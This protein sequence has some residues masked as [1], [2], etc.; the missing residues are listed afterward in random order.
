MI[1]DKVKFH[2]TR[3]DVI[4]TGRAKV[5]LNIVKKCSS[6][7]RLKT[8]PLYPQLKAPLPAPQTTPK[9]VTAGI[10]TS[11]QNPVS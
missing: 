10:Q 8:R 4:H 7:V 3:H 9:P 11:D 2:C 6:V 1:K 5:I